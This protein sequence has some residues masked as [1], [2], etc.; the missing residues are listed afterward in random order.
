MAELPQTP[1]LD[2]M[3]AVHSQSQVIGE[4]LDWLGRHGYVICRCTEGAGALLY[5]PAG[6]SAEERFAHHYQLQT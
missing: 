4:F 1:T 5:V 2:R 6:R 3:E